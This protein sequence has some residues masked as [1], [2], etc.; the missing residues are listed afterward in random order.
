MYVL[1]A[2]FSYIESQKTIT[3]IAIVEFRQRNFWATNQ[4]THRHTNSNFQ[5]RIGLEKCKKE[6]VGPKNPFRTTNKLLFNP[7]HDPKY[8]PIEL[9]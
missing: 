2:I 4:P 3:T 6:K 9:L 8:S 7:F 1:Y 5:D